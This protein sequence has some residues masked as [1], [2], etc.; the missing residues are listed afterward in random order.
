MNILH[1]LTIHYIQKHKAT[2]LLTLFSL[3]F[4]ITL[5]SSIILFQASYDDYQNRQHIFLY[6]EQD[7]KINLNDIDALYGLLTKQDIQKQNI[8]YDYG[9]IKN[10]NGDII[11][12]KSISS[13]F[14]INTFQIWEGTMPVKEND[15]MISQQYANH[16]NVH[17]HDQ[18]QID[19]IKSDLT[20]TGIYTPDHI[21]S[22][23]FI[24][25]EI[26]IYNTDEKSEGTLYIKLKDASKEKLSDIANRFPYAITPVSSQ[27]SPLDYLFTFLIL[28]TS[29]FV[30]LF[31]KNIFQIMLQEKRQ[32]IGMLKSIGITEQQLH[33]MQLF[34]AF[35]YTVISVP[36]AIFISMVIVSILLK[37][38]STAF[39][40]LTISP[41]KFQLI[42][43]IRI[44]LFIFI[45]LFLIIYLVEHMMHKQLK[46]LSIID[47]IKLSTHST[48]PKHH[49]R[50]SKKYIEAEIGKRYAKRSKSSHRAIVTALFISFTLIFTSSYLFT[51]S[52]QQTQNQ[53][54]IH[55]RFKN[56]SPQQLTD[57]LLIFQECSTLSG[58]NSYQFHS[59]FQL[60]QITI[61]YALFSP[62]TLKLFPSNTASIRFLLE[63]NNLFSTDD[64]IYLQNDFRYHNTNDSTK[65]MQF[66]NTNIDKITIQIPYIHND[67]FLYKTLEL[68]ITYPNDTTQLHV[69]NVYSNDTI[70]CPELYLSFKKMQQISTQI[71]SL[72]ISLLLTND[73]ELYGNPDDIQR[74][75]SSFQKKYP[76]WILENTPLDFN[77][78]AMIDQLYYQMLSGISILI[79]I[80]C[81][82]N[83]LCMMINQMYNR[84]K[85][86]A[87]M[88]S[89]GMEKRQIYCMLFYEN[90]SMI[91]IT[92]LTSIPIS[93]ALSYLF[94]INFLD[95]TLFFSYPLSI[96]FYTFLF[97]L[98]MIFIIL[99][100]GY[101][102]IK[103][104][105]IVELLYK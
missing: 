60:E 47:L 42:L 36:V 83:I 9:S 87:L 66:F 7:I 77:P 84:R 54:G 53:Q 93:I 5:I 19:S 62:Q 18:I 33:L 71:A 16:H 67:Q 63:T 57:A 101:H 75:L 58:V 20:V 48:V 105:N 96:L 70:P 44:F 89:I 43:D 82:M 90:S 99:Q 69:I 68:P 32:Y 50:F 65:T 81:F 55:V 8:V 10:Q 22:N 14:T 26:L 79:C 97:L 28:F 98:L 104:K 73:I 80:I 59:N 64:A 29:I 46:K 41:I 15:V 85:D 12:I 31:I 45:M 86:N 13:P 95:T 39:L 94:Y 24:S 91:L 103:Q 6:G 3:I 49:R 27:H 40:K 52:K 1:T 78:A 37:Q 102:I 38:F 74:A 34:E 72:D 51:I 25:D 4:S 11:Q 88:L 76:D 35:D 30:F 92:Y 61:P 21:A 23:S 100:T 2:T 56:T 17:I